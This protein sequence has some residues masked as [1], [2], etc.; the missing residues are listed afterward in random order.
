M[1]Y[2]TTPT[3]WQRGLM[4]FVL[5]ICITC[6]AFGGVEPYRNML[7]GK[8]RQGDSLIVKDEKFRNP[9]VV[10]TDITNKSVNNQLVL[11][12]IND[13]SAAFKKKFSCE[14]DLKIEYFAN[15]EQAEPIEIN[16][17]KL[18]VDYKP[19]GVAGWRREDIYKFT[20]GYWV[21]VTVN[22]ITSPELGDTIPAILELTS[23]ITIDR[24]YRYNDSQPLRIFGSFDQ[25]EQGLMQRYVGGQLDQP[26]DFLHL[27][28]TVVDGADEYDIEW[29]VFDEGAEFETQLSQMVAGTCNTCTQETLDNLFK[30]NATRITTTAMEYDVTMAYNEKYIVV[31]MRGIEYPDGGYRMEHGWNY[32]NNNNKYA[33]WKIDN[34]HQEKLNWQYSATFAEEGKKKEVVSYF[35]GSL[36]NR[37][38]VTVNNDKKIA[39]IQETIYDEFGRPAANILPAPHNDNKLKYYGNF[40]LN[41]DD[42]GYNYSDIVKSPLSV[43]EFKPDAL[44]T[45]LGAA[46]YYS[47]ANPFLGS[48]I[49]G[50]AESREQNLHNYVPD[51]EGYPFS[52]TT[53]ENDNTG[54]VKTQGG[55][56]PKFQP[57]VDLSV[58]GDAGDPRSAVT[59]NYY[60][61]PSDWELD[62]LFG[63]DV[64]YDNHYLKN[65]VVDPNGQL[66][67][68][69]INAAGK[70]IATALTGGNP[71]NLKALGS[72]KDPKPEV[73]SL[74]SA[75]EFEFDSRNLSI[76]ANTTVMAT[77][78]NQAF[79]LDYGL[80]QLI[81]Q[82]Q[83]NTAQI[84]SNCYYKMSIKITN[85]CEVEVYKTEDV[86][87]GSKLA[88]CSKNQRLEDYVC[89]S[90][91]EPGKYFITFELKLDRDVINDYTEEYIRKNTDLRTQF[92]FVLDYLGS[93]DFSSCFSEC[94]TCKATLG[95]REDFFQ[96]FKDKLAEFKMEFS[97]LTLADQQALQTLAYNRYDALL[98]D[99]LSKQATCA[100]DMCSRYEKLMLLDVSPGGQFALFQSTPFL[101]LENSSN[102][103]VQNFRK[104]FPEL[105]TSTQLYKDEVFYQEDGTM[106]SPHD[107]TFTVEKLVKY[108]R[109]EWAQRFLK[110]HPEYCKLEFCIS[111]SQ[112]LGWDEQVK[113]NINKVSEI[114]SIPLTNGLSYDNNNAAWLLTQDPFFAPGAPG[115]GYYSQM[116][117][118]LQEYS[119]RVM[120]QLVTL[121][122]VKSLTELVEFI[123]YCSDSEGNSNG[124]P[125]GDSWANCWPNGA[126][127][128]PDREWLLYR[129][130]YFQLKERYYNIARSEGA[131]LGKCQ[132]GTPLG[133]STCA[134]ISDFTIQES[135]TNN[136]V[137]RQLKITYAKGAAM[138]QMVLGLYYPAEYASAGIQSTL[139]FNNN[140]AEKS[141]DVPIGM[142]LG[143]LKIK[144][145]NCFGEIAEPTFQGRR[146]AP[147]AK[148]TTTS[149]MFPQTPYDPNL[150]REPFPQFTVEKGVACQSGEQG[151]VIT[152]RTIIGMCPDQSYLVHVYVTNGTTTYEV[153]VV[154]FMGPMFSAQVLCVP[155]VLNF[156]GVP[157]V[158]CVNGPIAPC[159]PTENTCPD[160]LKYKQSRF[161]QFNY[162]TTIG[163]QDVAN[164]K[165]EQLGQIKH[166]IISS[167]ESQAQA[168]VDRMEDCLAALPELERDAKRAALKAGFIDVCKR[169]GDVDHPWGATTTRPG[170]PNPSS[171]KEVIKSVMQLTN[172]TMDCNPYLIESPLPYESKQQGTP[173]ILT[174]S[175]AALCDQL[176]QLHTKHTNEAP[177]VSFYQYLVNIYGSAMTLTEAEVSMIEKSC[178]NCRF[179]LDQGI[180]LP[181]F[182]EPGMVGC[183][184]K[185]DYDAAKAALTAEFGGVLS[186]AHSN[187]EDVFSNFMNQR[188]GFLMPYS[189]YLEY[190]ATLVNNTTAILCNEPPFTSVQQDPYACLRTLVAA[191]ALKGSIAYDAY[192][193]EEKR[194][195]KVR[196][197][198]KCSWVNGM[199]KLTTDQQLYH[200]T[201]Y[202]YDQAGN[203][204]RTISPEGVRPLSLA[205]TDIVKQWRNFNPAT[206][207]GEGLPS[208]TDPYASLTALSDAMYTG[209]AKS[210]ELWLNANPGDY[211]RQVRFITPDN[212]YLW[213]AA[214]KDNMLWVEL[215]TL[216]PSP[217]RVNR[218]VADITSVNMQLWSHL[219][220]SSSNIV[221][222]TW[223]VYFEGK[224]LT[225]MTTGQ[226][227]YPFDA[228]PGSS[229]PPANYNY[230]KLLR[231]YNQP[232]TQAGVTAN[233]SNSCMMNEGFSAGQLIH[234]G[235]FNILHACNPA[236]ET[237]VVNNQGA[238]QVTGD[239]SMNDS[240]FENV[241]DNF[242]IEF[243]AKP[244]QP[245][246]IDQLYDGTINTAT[247][248][249]SGQRYAIYPTNA[250][251]GIG[252]GV[253][254]SVGTNGVSV[255][256]HDSGY[257]PALLVWQGTIN[258]WTHIAVVYEDRIPFLYINGQ[259]VATGQQSTMAYVCPG[260]NICSGPYGVMT[261]GIDEV[262][263]WRGARTFQQIRDN[264]QSGVS[265]ANTQ[266][267][268][269]WPLTAQAGAIIQDI[270]CN[271]HVLNPAPASF[272]WNTATLQTTIKD[273][274]P[275]EYAT[276]SYYPAHKLLTSYAFNSTGQV[277]RQKSPDGGDSYF[278]YDKLSR[279]IASQNEEQRFSGPK[280]SYTIYEK[281]TG[282]ITEVGEKS[283]AT[284][285][286]PANPGFVDESTINSFFATN[287][288]TN[289]SITETVYDARP[290]AGLG[291]N[292]TLTQNNLR[293]RVSA[294]LFRPETGQPVT[295]AS[296]YDYDLIGN[297]KTLWQQVD[298]LDVSGDLHRIDY[299][300]DLQSG[301]VNLVRYQQGKPDQFIYK[302]DYDAENRL[303]MASSGTILGSNIKRDASYYYYLHGPLGRAELGDGTQMVQGIDYAYTLQG[304]LKGVNG[305][306]LNAATEIGMDGKSGY[307]TVAKDVFGYSLGYFKDD[308]K[309]IGT[310]A[311]AFSLNYQGA[312]V[313]LTGKNLFNGN[314]SKTT[315]AISKFRNGD[316]VGYSYQYDQLNRLVEMRQHTLTGSTINWS[317]SSLTEAYLETITYDANGNIKT[318]K[319]NGANTADR[320]LVMDDLTYLYNG[321]QDP[322]SSDYDLQNNRLKRVTDAVTSPAYLEDIESQTED[323]QYDRIGNLIRDNNSDIFWTVYGKIDKVI[324]GTG[325]DPDRIEYSYD[326]GGNRVKK[327]S[328]LTHKEN[329]Q[330]VTVRMTTWYVRDA[331]GNVLGVYTQK[332][333]EP[334]KWQEQHLYGSSRIGMW[335]PN[336]ELVTGNGATEWG[337]AGKKSYEL[338]N[339]L[340]NVLAVVSDVVTTQPDNS[341]AATVKTAH[342]Y[343]PFGMQ[344]PERTFEAACR[345]EVEEPSEEVAN[346]DL[347][348]GVTQNGADFWQ[349]GV[350]WQRLNSATLA[351]ENGAIRCNNGGTSSDGVAAF[352][353][354]AGV[355]PNTTY[356]MEFDIVEKSTNITYFNCQAHTPGNDVYRVMTRKNGTG[357]HSFVFT[358][359][360]V[361]PQYIRL[362]ISSN[363]IS[364]G[365]FFSVDNF[366]CR[367]YKGEYVETPLVA[368]ANFDD[369]VMDGVN[370]LSNGMT[371]KPLLP[372]NST[373]SLTGTTDKKITVNCTNVDQ[374][375]LMTDIDAVSGQ[376]YLLKFTMTQ[377]LA[378]KRMGMR[379][380]S[381][382]N[383]VWDLGDLHGMFYV[384]SGNNIF[385]FKCP[386]GAD[387]IRIQMFRSNSGQTYDGYN[388]PYTID[389]FSLS[390]VVF[391]PG[392]TTTVCDPGADPYGMDGIYRYGFNGKENDND[393]KGSGNQMDYG[394]RIYD[395][396]L[397]RFLSVDP[398]TRNYPWY[399]PYQFAGNTPIQAIDL[400]GGEEKHYTLDLNKDGTATLTNIPSK[401]KEYNEIP[402]LMR[403]FTL[404]AGK[405]KYAIQPRAVVTFGSNTYK[406]G[407]AS[408]L[409]NQ[410]KMGLF[411]EILKNPSS[412]NVA[413]F[414][415]TFHNE[416]QDESVAWFTASVN[417]QNNAVMNGPFLTR[418]AWFTANQG[419][420]NFKSPLRDRHVATKINQKSLAKEWNTVALP[421]VDFQADVAAINSGNASRVRDMFYTNGRWYSAHDGTLYPVSGK[422]LF[423]L[424]RATFKV[425]GVL[426]V[427][428]DT[429]KSAGI[430]KNMKATSEQLQNARE[431]YNLIKEVKK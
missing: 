91:P 309:P 118:D 232:A 167:C 159:N 119:H 234:A 56:G 4:L 347:T 424:D 230:V 74:L 188:F 250:G 113:I 89:R 98:A 181:V 20:N 190:E 147:A 58:T 67:I 145:I 110:Y 80:N 157:M 146:G 323:Y 359:P 422:G 408:S 402:F 363:L 332:E 265:P 372:E 257:M 346:S 292:G 68:S 393:V 29:A 198:E 366:V 121:S 349:N 407:F 300:Y 196:Y 245:H 66:S 216:Q 75:A 328:K 14:L 144:T 413:E 354:M 82:Y 400:D 337:I 88:D 40:N 284:N 249:T 339:H 112:F 172:L 380:Y 186:T 162:N 430:L 114:A 128:V 194:L 19:G 133:L 127:R 298:G 193:E 259:L 137:Q 35:D 5:T 355:A 106:T 313:D 367:K 195:F 115:A 220:V 409:T 99:C 420:H 307:Q 12:L 204:I 76:T 271:G 81:E 364:V 403:L 262:R 214:V 57:G 231:F 124:A 78:A 295:N 273:I 24:K 168:W 27:T 136:G 11:R 365:T 352:I 95:A 428:G 180:Q 175:S 411:N 212:R 256:E 61:K 255:Y 357:H 351:Y 143:A 155:P 96:V 362:R 331:Q 140:E 72:K 384:G 248:G 223:D 59:R 25:A 247:M 210:V 311:T 261:G 182:L 70:T 302:Y 260:S 240:R 33:I 50:D 290:A 398:L 28:W 226:P 156:D 10:W 258:Q 322:V 312:A 379:I 122:P 92:N 330:D 341:L 184:K 280:Y 51:A 206:C 207:T 321:P 123:L 396:R 369:G 215:Y 208:V 310:G 135:G 361:M 134:N 238:M 103:L 315:L 15:V 419:T 412:V 73:L 38:T 356:V 71:A 316:P 345:E 395:P 386:A 32:T 49:L 253:G 173:K 218:A 8:I 374:S 131:C 414:T 211:T 288:G 426:N 429:E 153:G 254:V 185:A 41:S 335:S 392:Q 237:R 102:V 65:M 418:K 353:P 111:N 31:R 304:W 244:D 334:K 201:L 263:I 84:C 246:E 319:R 368:S 236:T 197:V 107:A 377:S 373:I 305:D 152:L 406:I 179:I 299:E 54:R 388:V 209:T 239:L 23:Q 318:Y 225:L 108:W 55:V 163:Q 222:G 21:K 117:T 416:D 13:S 2:L 7:T 375:H 269:Y 329:G 202:Y 189:R 264:Y 251:A 371:F 16:N 282:R 44:K 340:G 158:A 385:N 252:A 150:C 404:G 85:D 177:G 151:L 314:I 344:M 45:T 105:P 294:T 100:P 224:K 116:S 427:F 423:R 138:R 86:I 320:P 278:W 217:V 415:S 39:I 187:Y 63:N 285:G 425:L 274:V 286:M 338:T 241:L 383:G 109:P 178:N 370:V 52:V 6:T 342:D 171:F 129:E 120:S 358:T 132:V 297:V 243:W 42:K 53:Y 17:V 336:M 272:T 149:S 326:P 235:R 267:A 26:Q 22:N 148:N 219:V 205:E 287:N 421:G 303:T 36:R 200:Y 350:R 405:S 48:S 34:W 317:A 233:F 410:D 18:K 176:Q 183:I 327:F 139:T 165:N 382:I 141:V 281:A 161:Q 87:V 343:Y 90:F 293:K 101:A 154:S 213:Q 126:C 191:A 30:N 43:C 308:Y 390:H 3:R 164:I 64:G 268:T 47:P 203:L 83:G 391:L 296:Y 199:A 228:V 69:Y 37:Q 142:P 389:N 289:K 221:N 174:N 394:L 266:L 94:V 291:V 242:S 93:T 348:S 399:T 397:G 325:P 104:E 275:V 360:A 276:R 431:V 192:I 62:R 306:K 378:D 229:L 170:D 1:L 277:V 283:G 77:Q 333:G 401:T 169:G 417:L 279:L 376:E 125:S 324:K 9:A 79:R 381:R 270:S 60:G 166:Q 46:A 387:R 301:K 130:Y 227:A 160:L 97:Q